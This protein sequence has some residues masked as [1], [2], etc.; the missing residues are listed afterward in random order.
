MQRHHEYLLVVE[1][2]VQVDLFEVEEIGLWER[3]ICTLCTF[4]NNG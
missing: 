3:E 4:V 1:V 2:E